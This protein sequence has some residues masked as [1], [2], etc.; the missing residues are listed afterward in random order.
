MKKLLSIL[1]IAVLGISTTF[2]Q[3]SVSATVKQTPAQVKVTAKTPVTVKKVVA[4]KPTVPVV[5]NKVVKKVTVTTP[6]KKDG[7]ADMRYKVNKETKVVVAGP[8]KKDG[9]ADMR[10]KVNKAAKKN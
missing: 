8:K 3:T 4:V 7:T 10:Y 1:A 6:T 5:A 9:N 2:A